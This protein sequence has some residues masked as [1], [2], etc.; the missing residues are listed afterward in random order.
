MEPLKKILEYKDQLNL[1][2]AKELGS[3]MFEKTFAPKDLGINYRTI[4]HWD[5]K[6]LLMPEEPTKEPNKWR[7]FSFVELIWIDLAQEI[8]TL[9]YSLPQLILLKKNLFDSYDMNEFLQRFRL[10]TQGSMSKGEQK[11]FS[12]KKEQL[13]K[14]ERF[15][16][17]NSTQVKFT[18]KINPL[19]PIILM[20]L[21]DREDAVFHFYSDGTFDCFNPV[22]SEKNDLNWS[23]SHISVTFSTIMQKYLQR[24]KN[25]DNAFSLTALSKDELTVLYY[26][27]KGD[28]KSLNINFGKKNTIQL[29][30]TKEE[31]KIDLESRFLDHILKNGYQNITFKTQAGK[32]TTFERTTK[33]KINK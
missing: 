27:R 20:F 24:D 31:K 28:L 17:K 25:L 32:L 9:G 21:I 2:S 5:E 15:K 13:A 14:A 23:R 19:T 11:I 4:V 8:R 6:G 22:S 18:Q 7:A 10:N 16:T 3:I 26:L 29:I 1:A 12:D 33:H 30:E